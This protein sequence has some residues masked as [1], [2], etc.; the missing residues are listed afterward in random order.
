MGYA[1]IEAA[2]QFGAS[3]KVISGPISLQYPET[4]DVEH[5]E[6]ADQ[7]LISSE[8]N[9]NW[10]DIV[11]CVAAVSDYKPDKAPM[12]KLKKG[13]DDK[14]L[15]EIHMVKN[16]DIL[17]TLSSMRRENQIFVGFAA[18]TDDVISCGK[19]K[20]VSKGVDMIV[21]NKVGTKDG[22]GQDIETATIITSDLEL[23]LENESKRSIAT[24]II[25]EIAKIL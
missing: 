5:V 2:L 17:A 22:F 18:E 13:I 7:M 6:T 12:R 4:F 3:V 25:R 8:A 11:I 24:E 16:P 19:S 10:A 20:L 9:L 21:A 15:S 23:A 1:L 14:A